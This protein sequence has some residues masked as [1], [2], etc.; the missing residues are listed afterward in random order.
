MSSENIEWVEFETLKDLF[1][2][3]V[4]HG[5][6]MQQYASVLHYREYTYVMAPSGNLSII[7]YTKEA[8]QAKVYKWDLE[9]NE[10]TPSSTLD[11]SNYNI[12]IQEAMHDSLL[13]KH[14]SK[15]S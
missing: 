10:F 5:I 13:E 15:K 6:P 12:I 2:F 11:K 7:F 3:I 4:T 14:F 8:P 9:Q 1:Y